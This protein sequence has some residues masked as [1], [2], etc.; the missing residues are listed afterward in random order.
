MYM[1]SS[2]HN[3]FSSEAMQIERER[4]TRSNGRL[5]SSFKSMRALIQSRPASK[6]QIIQHFSFFF[7]GGTLKIGLY[8][9]ACSRSSRVLYMSQRTHTQMLTFHNLIANHIDWREKIFTRPKWTRARSRTRHN[10]TSER[11][12]NETTAI[13]CLA[14]EHETSQSRD[15]VIVSSDTFKAIRRNNPHRLLDYLASLENITHYTARPNE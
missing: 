4:R 15:K 3:H 14:V 10:G 12:A 6:A 9:A 7:F 13:K 1:Y 2:T 8:I 11:F 5:N